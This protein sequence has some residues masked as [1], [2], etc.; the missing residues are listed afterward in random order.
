M[1]TQPFRIE[2]WKNNASTTLDGAVSATDTTI[3]VDSATNFPSSGDFRILIDNSEEAVV[4]SVSGLVFTL[5]A[6]LASGHGDGVNV[7]LV[8][9]DAGFNRVW[10]DG[11]GETDY[12][13]NRILDEGV[14]RTASD[15][16]WLNQ[17]SATCVDADDG[18]L[19]MTTPSEA[20]HQIR[21]KYLTAPSTPWLVVMRLE[22]G[23]GLN[24]GSSGSYAG[25]ILRESSTSKLYILGLQVNELFLW[26]MTNPTTFSAAVDSNLPSHHQDMW[27]RLEDD[28]TDIKGAM[29]LDGV[30]W[31]EA[32]SEGRTAH[33]S[34]GPDQV[35]FGVSNGS[36]AAGMLTHFKSWI[37]E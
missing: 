14:T 15:F 12:P 18:G 4:K 25:I 19:N 28:G 6:G 1:V 9:T 7:D 10:K 22:M 16:T 17:G 20:N 30:Q 5:T 27:L 2:R 3:T 29:S 34:G 24:R 31:R 32:W 11:F 8:Q 26:R 33:M 13:W 37:L 35:G 23:P 21:G 36:G